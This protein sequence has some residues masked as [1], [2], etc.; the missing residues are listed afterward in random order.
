MF[1]FSI[2]KVNP[3]MCK[4]L[5]IGDVFIQNKD[6]QDRKVYQVM[7]VLGELKLGNVNSCQMYNKEGYNG[8]TRQEVLDILSS[9]FHKYSWTFIP[10]ED[11]MDKTF[12]I[13]VKAD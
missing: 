12:T 3:V 7:E 10:V 6:S 5:Q 13:T 1:N 8:M 4:E 11:I 2:K 9:H